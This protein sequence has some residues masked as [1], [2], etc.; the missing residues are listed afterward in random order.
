MKMDRNAKIAKELVRIAKSL[1]AG[2]ENIELIYDKDDNVVWICNIKFIT[3]VICS[4]VDTAKSNLDTFVSET[5]QMFDK[6][7][8]E[9]SSNNLI[10]KALEKEPK[11]GISTMNHINIEAYMRV[12]LQEEIDMGMLQ[13]ICNNIGATFKK[14]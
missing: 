3:H 12:E 4:N 2:H 9:C 1:V 13:A 8:S 7:I 5:Q 6:F 11:L 14:Q 10:I